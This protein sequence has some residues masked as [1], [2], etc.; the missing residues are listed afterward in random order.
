MTLRGFVD[1]FR[2]F[3]TILSST[4]S[5]FLT[6][7]KCDFEHFFHKKKIK[8]RLLLGK[9][10]EKI[11]D[12]KAQFK[13]K[14]AYFHVFQGKK[15]KKNQNHTY[16]WSKK[17]KYSIIRLKNDE[18]IKKPLKITTIIDLKIQQIGR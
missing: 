3:S 16:Y 8:T 11:A 14:V 12:N 2:H 9:K 13:L 17:S 4:F 7:N 18:N 10:V 15:R 1:I 6:Y 5:N